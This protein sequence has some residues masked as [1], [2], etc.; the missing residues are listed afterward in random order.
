[1]RRNLRGYVHFSR[2]FLRDL[3]DVGWREVIRPLHRR[4]AIRA[5][6]SLGPLRSR[7]AVLARRSV[8]AR[9]SLRSLDVDGLRV[10]LAA[11]VRPAQKARIAHAGGK[12]YAVLAIGAVC[13]VLTGC[14]VFTLRPLRTGITFLTLRTLRAGF[15]VFAGCPIRTCRTG[16]ALRARIAFVAL[17][18]LQRAVV[19]KSIR[20]A[21]EDVNVVRLTSADPVSVARLGRGLV[22][23]VQRRLARVVA[24]NPE[25][26]ACVSLGPL[27]ALLAL[28][29]LRANCAGIPFDALFA[30]RPLRTRFTC[31]TL[32]ALGSGITGITLVTLGSLWAGISRFALRP[33]LAR[34]ALRAFQRSNL[35][36]REVIIGKGVAFVAFRPLRTSAAGFAGIPLGALNALNALDALLTLRALRTRC[37]CVALFSLWALRAC[38]AGIPLGAGRAGLAFGPLLT[39]VTLGS[40]LS[41]RAGCRNAGIGKGSRRRV[42]LEPV[43][44]RAVD[45][46]HL[47]YGAL[48]ARRRRKHLVHPTLISLRRVDC[49]F[50]HRGAHARLVGLALGDNVAQRVP[51]L[52]LAPAAFRRICTFDKPDEQPV[53]FTQRHGIRGNVAL[54]LHDQAERAARAVCLAPFLRNV[55]GHPAGLVLALP[56]EVDLLHPVCFL[57]D[58]IVTSLMENGAARAVF[59]PLLRRVATIFRVSRNIHLHMVRFRAVLEFAAHCLNEICGRGVL[60]H[61]I[62]DGPQE[63]SLDLHGHAALNQARFAVHAHQQVVLVLSVVLEQPH[64]DV[65]LACAG[66]VRS[67]I[68]FCFTHRVS[69]RFIDGGGVRSR[70]LFWLGQRGLVKRRGGLYADHVCLDQ[71]LGDLGGLPADGRALVKRVSST[72]RAKRLDDVLKAAAGQ[73]GRTVS[74]SAHDEGRVDVAALRA[75]LAGIDDVARNRRGARDF[76]QRDRRATRSRSRSGFDLADLAL[77]DGHAARKR[78]SVVRRNNLIDGDD[79][80]GNALDLELARAFRQ[81]VGVEHLRF[82]RLHEADARDLADLIVIDVGGVLVLVGALPVGVILNVVGA[83]RVND[84]PVGALVAGRVH[85]L[86]E[87]D[88]LAHRANGEV[89]VAACLAAD[90]Q[91]TSIHLAFAVL[92]V[93]SAVDDLAG[94]G[95]QRAARLRA[96]QHRG[97]L[98]VVVDGG[99]LEDIRDLHEVAVLVDLCRQRGHR[100]LAA[101]GRHAFG[102]GGERLGQRVVLAELDLLALA[103]GNVA[104]LCE[105]VMHQL[106]LGVVDQ[107][108]AVIGLHLAGKTGVGGHVRLTLEEAQHDRQN[109]N[110]FH[111]LHCFISLIK[112][113]LGSCASKHD[114]LAAPHASC[115]LCAVGFRKLA[116]VILDDDPRLGVCS[117]LVR[118]HPLRAHVIHH[119][120]FHLGSRFRCV[121]GLNV[122]QM[123][124]LVSVPHGNTGAQHGNEARI[125]RHLASQV[126]VRVIARRVRRSD[127]LACLTDPVVIGLVGFLC[128]LPVLFLPFEL[129]ILLLHLQIL[130]VLLNA[131]AHAFGF[132]LIKHRSQRLVT[133]K[134]GPELRHI[135]VCHPIMAHERVDNGLCIR[136]LLILGFFLAESAVDDAL[137][138]CGIDVLVLAVYEIE[139]LLFEVSLAVFRSPGVVLL[140]LCALV[141]LRLASRRPRIV[142]CLLLA[143]NNIGVFAR[144]AL[145]GGRR[146]CALCIALCAACSFCAARC[147]GSGSRSGSAAVKEAQDHSKRVFEVHA[148]PSYGHIAGIWPPVWAKRNSLRVA[149]E[150]PA[151][152]R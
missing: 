33:A 147:T 63:L 4:L 119:A 70:P 3:F 13:S 2:R 12:R 90:E 45:V 16:R 37:T 64:A 78:L 29:P 25:S 23:R 110:V 146:A 35:R 73:L 54:A 82:S 85:S 149:V 148:I 72:G 28:R 145:P 139:E 11:V 9:V 26:A 125:L 118:A 30:L 95:V 71:T 98:K 66:G 86:Q 65:F 21:V 109:E 97:L 44:R 138:L 87:A 20:H 140:H 101:L 19:D 56:A 103:L 49:A 96:E 50:I 126:E 91:M 36:F 24:E 92:G 102:D 51:Q 130:A 141:V 47:G 111:V 129:L 31:V 134:G 104:L 69:L 17:R 124:Y 88:R 151:G 128:A 84:G 41:L 67:R 55:E 121:A 80:A 42:P 143:K 120:F 52:R 14:S 106:G 53:L 117:V 152:K 81:V 68:L 116:R 40:L 59:C 8:R 105:A 10:R 122:A 27:D 48:H 123:R 62:L 131:H 107:G 115:D 112:S 135:A 5:R 108:V 113:V 74:L 58:H 132:L 38:R 150:G 60:L 6:V 93:G 46:W 22:C 32:G 61:L 99:E 100:Q 133:V 34:V 136:D 144:F 1:M 57:F 83:V 127:Q 142:R 7:T 79:L 39:G 137:R 18:A 89:V 94:D 75:S 76:L 114:A 15:S 77:D 43:P